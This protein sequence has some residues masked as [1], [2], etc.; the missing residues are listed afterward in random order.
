MRSRGLGGGAW[1]NDGGGLANSLAGCR[2]WRRVGD[3]TSRPW[4]GWEREQERKRAD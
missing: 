3:S 1:N 4:T 2:C